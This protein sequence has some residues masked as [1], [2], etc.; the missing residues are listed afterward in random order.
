MK[1]M[2]ICRGEANIAI[3]PEAPQEDMFLSRK[4]EQEGKNTQF[5]YSQALLIL[6][7]VYKRLCL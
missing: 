7:S 4:K 6:P 3:W 2:K 1:P 5:K